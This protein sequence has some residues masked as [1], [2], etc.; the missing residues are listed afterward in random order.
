MDNKL[1]G[2]KGEKFAQ[3]LL[4]KNGYKIL[5]TKFRTKLGEIDIVAKEKDTLVFVEVKTRT[6]QK[7][8]KP[9]EAVNVRKLHTIKNAGEL[10]IR[11]HPGLAKKF[12]IDV[13]AIEV[14]Y[15]IVTSA[16][17]IQAV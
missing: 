7:F 13:V 14:N 17:I 4:I 15:G 2:D 12:R 10:F 5:A 3:N 1:F 6:S 9:Q 8:G 16:K 11:S